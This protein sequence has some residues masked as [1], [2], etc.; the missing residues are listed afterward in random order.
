MRRLLRILVNAATVLSLL[1]CL[2]TAVLWVRADQYT[3]RLTY[4]AGQ[5]LHQLCTN[6]TGV[7]YVHLAT[8]SRGRSRF[9]IY[10]WAGWSE[11]FGIYRQLEA[12]DTSLFLDQIAPPWGGYTFTIPYWLLFLVTAVAPGIWLTK[13]L[14]RKRTLPGLCPK[15]QYD[16]RAT[17]DRCPECGTV[18]AKGS[19]AEAQK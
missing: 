16:L 15:C 2:A 6:S 3:N 19:S 17:P 5:T 4:N 13:R 9:A 12:V 18:V 11:D 14:R 8:A 1:V 10:H 7:Q